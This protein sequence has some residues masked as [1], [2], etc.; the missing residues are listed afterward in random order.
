MDGEKE[1][2]REGGK[3]SERKKGKSNLCVYLYV[4][5]S[6][7]L[8]VKSDSPAI[9]TVRLFRDSLWPGDV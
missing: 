1:R 6:H 4:F 9:S 8:L 7:L 5:T 3:K 2:E